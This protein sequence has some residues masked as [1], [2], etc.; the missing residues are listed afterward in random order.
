VELVAELVADHPIYVLVPFPEKCP[1]AEMCPV[2]VAD[3]DLVAGTVLLGGTPLVVEMVQYVVGRGC[4]YCCYLAVVLV[5]EAVD[6][7]HQ[8]TVPEYVDIHP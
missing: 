6:R 5:V 1:H 3:S 2:A 4:G 7:F 8:V